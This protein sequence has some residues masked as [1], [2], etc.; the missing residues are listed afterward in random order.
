MWVGSHGVILVYSITNRD[1]FT[2]IEDWRAEAVKHG[3]DNIK[4]LL[5]GNKSDCENDRE[6]STDEGIVDRRSLHD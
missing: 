5:V 3:G 1:S 2:A 4:M 6:V